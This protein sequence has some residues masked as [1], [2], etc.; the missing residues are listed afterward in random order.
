M[1]QPID[2]QAI[3]KALAASGLTLKD[4][5][6]ALQQGGAGVL[7][8]PGQGAG[9]LGDSLPTA[10]A[11]SAPEDAAP[12]DEADAADTEGPSED[13][14]GDET[15]PADPESTAEDS[16]EVDESDN[17]ASPI[18]TALSQNI[19][20]LLTTPSDVQWLTDVVKQRIRQKLMQRG[21]VK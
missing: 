6:A 3:Q 12:A 16:T 19:S 9:V 21:T 17:Q 15:D 11:E 10:D 1:N 14:P 5:L 2:L 7:S 8:Q 4:V 18:P 20:S 13:V